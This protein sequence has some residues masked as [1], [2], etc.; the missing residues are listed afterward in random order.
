MGKQMVGAY[1]FMNTISSSDFIFVS[2]G[3]KLG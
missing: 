1:Y 3:V 2:F